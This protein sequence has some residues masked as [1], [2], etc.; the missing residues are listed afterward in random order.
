MGTPASASNSAAGTAEEKRM[1]PDDEKVYTLA[2][3]QAK[4]KGEFTPAEINHYW[5]HDM[6]PLRDKATTRLKG[7]PIKIWLEEVRGEGVAQYASILE[8][9]YDSVDQMLL[10]YM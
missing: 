7:M 6:N 4:F 10:I 8:E 1:D 5:D 9:N 2:E 3:L